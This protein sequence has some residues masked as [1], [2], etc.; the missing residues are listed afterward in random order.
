MRDQT[1]PASDGLPIHRGGV[2]RIHLHDGASQDLDLAILAY[3]MSFYFTPRSSL[4]RR[5][6]FITVALAAI[7]SACGSSGDAVSDSPSIDSIAATTT[8][9]SDSTEPAN[10]E[11]VPGVDMR[12]LRYCE[13]LLL[14]MSETGLIAEVYNTYPLNDCPSDQWAALDPAAIA[15]EAGVP[16]ALA[17][18]PRY[19]LMDSVRKSDQ[20][21]IVTKVFGGLAM[22]RYAQVLVGKPETVGVPYTAQSV[23]RKSTFAFAAGQTVYVLVTPEGLEYIMQSWSQ[24]SDPALS[25][26]DLANL[27]SRLQLPDDWRYE[28]RVLDQELV[29]DTSNAPARVLQDELLNSYSLIP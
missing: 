28:S 21:S 29:V 18:G 12:G 3:I 27:G 14:S 25:E 7:T 23:D 13:I 22:N 17:N 16:L 2:L 8:L 19:W 9:A 20:D 24:Q 15:L 4:A 5:L 6:T 26:S 10:S 11:P 1:R